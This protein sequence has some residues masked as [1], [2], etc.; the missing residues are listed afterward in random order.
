MDPVVTAVLALFTGVLGTEV[1][2]R[3]LTA[4][5]DRETVKQGAQ[6]NLERSSHKAFVELTNQA[7]EGWRQATLAVVQMTERLSEH[8]R[9]AS[10]WYEDLKRRSE[11]QTKCMDE[12][13]QNQRALVTILGGRKPDE[14]SLE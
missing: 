4:S 3:L 12:I 13:L 8:D 14:H 2:K 7:M 11:I 9:G 6:I 10:Y 1:I 5:V